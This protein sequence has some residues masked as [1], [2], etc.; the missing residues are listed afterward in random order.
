M[1]Y[2]FYNL[3]GDIGGVMGLLLGTS[4][5]SLYDI[6]GRFVRTRLNSMAFPIN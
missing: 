1:V 3:I 6:A 2:D 5:I 4:F